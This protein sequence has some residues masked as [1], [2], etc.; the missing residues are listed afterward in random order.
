[1]YYCAVAEPTVRTD[2]VEL[3]C[4]AGQSNMLTVYHIFYWKDLNLHFF[5]YSKETSDKLS[6]EKTYMQD[7]FFK[8]QAWPEWP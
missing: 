1:M 7:I 6:L 2:D 3:K 4:Q 5:L 8:I